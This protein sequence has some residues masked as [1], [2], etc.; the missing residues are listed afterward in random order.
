MK[1]NVCF[2]IAAVEN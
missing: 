2:Y 1:L